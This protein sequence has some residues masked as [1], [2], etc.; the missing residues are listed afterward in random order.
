METM[1][2]QMIARLLWPALLLKQMVWDHG[3]EP[4]GCWECFLEETAFAGDEGW[5]GL[6]NLPY[7]GQSTSE[8]GS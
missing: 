7:R 1:H 3:W 8:T 4:L 2:K 6:C 5:P